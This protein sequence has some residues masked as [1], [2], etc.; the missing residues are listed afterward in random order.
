MEDQRSTDV[1]NDDEEEYPIKL[2]NIKHFE[3]FKD[4]INLIYEQVLMPLTTPSSTV[5]DL[6]SGMREQ[7]GKIAVSIFK[8]LG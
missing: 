6:D 8:M 2:F 5:A 3:E 7:F 1:A 4:G